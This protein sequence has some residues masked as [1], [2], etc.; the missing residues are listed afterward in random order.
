MFDRVEGS[1]WLALIGGGEFSFGETLEADLAWLA[2]GPE[3]TIGFLPTASGSSDY[4]RHFADYL[5]EEHGRRVE[6]IPIY[7][8]RDARRGK[9]LERIAAVA[10]VYVGGGVTDQLLDTV[11][12]TQVTEALLDKLRS[13]GTVVAIA[14]GAQALGTV[15]RSLYG[16]E[17]VPGLGWLRRGGVE[18]NFDP[19]HDRR[20]R[21]LMRQP[22]VDWGIGL[23]AGAAL[24]LGPGGEVEMVGV[25]F[26]LEDPDGDLQVLGTTT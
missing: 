9:N 20:L 5:E 13:G 4:P 3:G 21:E 25:A 8:E 24:L 1:G 12:D 22:A 2:K 26:A 11:R 7:R 16:G 10:G 17:A 18:T 23:P 14:A 6:T 15:A 19:G